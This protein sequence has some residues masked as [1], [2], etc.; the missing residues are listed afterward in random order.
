M[1]V[2]SSVGVV[3]TRTNTERLAGSLDCEHFGKCPGC[4]VDERVADTEIVRSAKRYFSSP[5][6]RK[7]RLDANQGA[8]Y[9]SQE[10]MK[11]DGFYRVVVPSPLTQWRTQAM[12]ALEA[13]D[14][15]PIGRYARWVFQGIADSIRDGLFVGASIKSIGSIETSTG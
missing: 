1:S 9:D 10:S 11:D 3:P 7:N 2:P 15:Y 6:V 12:K 4:V 8:M 13:H 5:F 14:I